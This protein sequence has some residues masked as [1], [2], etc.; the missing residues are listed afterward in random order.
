MEQPVIECI[1]GYPDGDSETW[2]YPSFEDFEHS[3]MKKKREEDIKVIVWQRNGFKF[4][5]EQLERLVY[6]DKTLRSKWLAKWLDVVN[7]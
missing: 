4:S 7:V 6:I 1:F 3:V 5:K 2:A